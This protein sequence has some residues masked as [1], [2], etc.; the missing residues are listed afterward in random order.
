MTVSPLIFCERTGMWALAWRKSLRA[1]SVRLI[2]TRSPA[3]CLERLAE[4]P[5]A[6][7]SLEWR[8]ENAESTCEILVRCND[9]FPAA[10][11]IVTADRGLAD[12]EALARE[13][14]AAWFV[15]STRQLPAL[16]AVVC[17][18]LARQPLAALSLRERI[19]G[20]LPW[21][22]AG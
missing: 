20:Q 15:T 6:A 19:W 7:V 16:A 8:A 13:A 1:T 3:E 9:E 2:E 10:L 18:H 12:A 14:G 4:T 21:D 11:A 17:R 22:R 5:A